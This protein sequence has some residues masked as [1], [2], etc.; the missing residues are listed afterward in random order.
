MSDGAMLIFFIIVLFFIWLLA[1][2][3]KHKDVDYPFI[4]QQNAQIQ[5]VTTTNSN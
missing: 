2:G 1:G 4:K 3:Q 5:T